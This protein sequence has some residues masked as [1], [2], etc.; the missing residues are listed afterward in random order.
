MNKLKKFISLFLCATAA[1]SIVA[2]GSPKAAS[3]GGTSADSGE[4]TSL[5]FYRVGIPI[6]TTEDPVVQE[7]E[8]RTNTKIEFITA[9]WDQ[10]ASRVNTLLASGEQMDIISLDQTAVTFQEMARNGVFVQ[11]DEYLNTD[12]WPI[13]AALA[14]DPM[15]SALLVDGKCYGIP[16]PIEPGGGWVLGFR[17]DWLDNVGLDIPKTPE[18]L[19]E[20]FKAFKYND[21]DGNGI[22]DTMALTCSTS[23]IWDA[24]MCLYCPPVKWL[25]DD[26]GK[27]QSHYVS[28]NYRKNMEFLNRLYNEELINEDLF[29]IKER[30]LTSDDFAIGKTGISLEASWSALSAR[31]ISANPNA[32][33]SLVEIFPHDPDYTDGSVAAN[34]WLWMMCVLPSTCS[35]PEKALDLLEYLNSYEGRVLMSY[36]IEGVNYEELTV[37]ENNDIVATGVNRDAQDENWGGDSQH[38]LSWGL[39]NTIVGYADVLSA[40]GDISSALQNYQLF[41]SDLEKEENVFYDQRRYPTRQ[42]YPDPLNN[43]VLST[44]STYGG[45]VSSVNEEYRVKLVAD[46]PTA[47]EFDKNWEEY[48]EEIYAV[49]LDKMEEEANQLYTDLNK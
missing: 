3:D 25:P 29:T 16:Q 18:E 47:E 39:G 7:L 1:V 43:H 9:P 4:P 49:G 46:S 12:K 42:L 38:P 8:K 17:Q 15:Y 13:E 14:Y 19:Y 40:K 24:L 27:L 35:D 2:C 20:V 48:V 5:K 32:K 37:D 28:E 30:N 31:T 44:Q 6:D 11:L 21:P 34:N 10:D 41:T 22:D 33:I 23:S 45:R 26:S 36:G